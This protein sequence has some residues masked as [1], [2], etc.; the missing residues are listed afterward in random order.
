MT[1][2]NNIKKFLII[3]SWAKEQ[4]TVKNIKENSSYKVFCY[5][6]TK[7]PGIISLVDGYRMGSLYK[8]DEIVEY[9]KA[10]QPDLVLV[11]TAAPLSLG[12]VNK[13]Q[14]AQIPVFGPTKEASKLECN[15][16]FTR[17]LMRKYNI[18]NIPAFEVFKEKE[19]AIEFAKK[20]DWN[21]AVKPIG[22][23]EGLGVKVAGEQ[24]E[25][26]EEIIEY[27]VK[28]LNKEIGGSPKV[29]IEEKIEGEEFTIQCLVHEGEII[30]TPAVQD[31]KKLLPGDE[32]P[33][34]ASMGSYST[35]D[36]IL[37]FLRKKEYKISLEIIK[38]TVEAFKKETGQ[39]CSGFLYGQF[40]LTPKGIKLVE[41]NF[42]PGD[43]EWMNTLSVLKNNIGNV[44]IELMEG[45]NVEL[46]FISKA[47]VCKYIV[48]KNYPE[49]L[50]ENLEVSFP[51]G[52]IKEMGVDWYYS[53]GKDEKSGKLNVGEER[54]IAFIGRG[55]T[56]PEA[57]KKVEKGISCIKGDFRYRNDIG[58]AK[59][60]SSKKKKVM[61]RIR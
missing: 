34:T 39:D 27:V 21:V 22:L 54:G 3:G 5:L 25:N 52:K 51:K 59:M 46:T 53:C 4:I 23:T 44:V 43:P 30:S 33:N 29:L 41:Y 49:E 32:G 16:A 14:K 57:N 17:N 18:N 19:K 15:K 6:D 11:T 47:T 12:L 13:L 38:K 31:F 42:R 9:A 56:V 20:M 55:E 48:P 45:K 7:N 58:T 40:I 28:I 24:L 50:N 2:R 61:E 36:Y 10:I 35:R 1:P 26:K 37:P 60:I 8:I